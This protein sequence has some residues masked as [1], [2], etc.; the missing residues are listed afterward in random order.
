MPPFEPLD[1]RSFLVASVA[2]SSSLLVDCRCTPT[3]MTVEPLAGFELVRAVRDL[4][5]AS[6]DHLSARAADVIATKDP[7]TAVRF[8]RD[9]IAVLPPSTS[10]ETSIDGVRFGPNAVLRAG[11]GTLRERA[12]LLVA[13]LNAMG[14]TAK[15][16]SAPRPASLTAAELYRTRP[17]LYGVDGAKLTQAARQVEAQTLS[18]L[19]NPSQDP[20]VAAVLAKVQA[21]LPTSMMQA[22][23][24]FDGVDA[25]LPLV[26]YSFGGL[27]RWAYAVGTLDEVSTAP[28]SVSGP[29]SATDFPTVSIKLLG[30]PGDVRGAPTPTQLVELVAASWRTDEVAGRRV[31]IAFPPPDPANVIGA[32]PERLL[33]RLPTISLQSSPSD[34]PAL[35][36]PR[37]SEPKPMFT[38]KAITL[39]GAAFSAPASE[40]G[41]VIGP[42]GAFANLD[43]TS[44]A[45][46]VANVATIEA[47]AHAGAFP[48]IDLSVSV[49][50]AGGNPVLGLTAEDFALTDEGA[51]Q[52]LNVLSNAAPPPLKVLLAYDCSGS[53]TFPTAQARAAFENTLATAFV[54][55]AAQRPFSLGTALVGSAPAGYVAPDRTTI[56]AT[57]AA[58]ASTSDIW[59]TLGRVALEGGASVV[60]IASD[61]DASDDPSTIPAL[62][63]RLAASGIAVAAVPLGTVS[64]P[65]LDA[66]L[67]LSR[68]VKLDPSAPTFGQQLTDFIGAA[69][70]RA[71]LSAYRLR[72]RLAGPSPVEK[73]QRTATVSVRTVSGNAAYQVPA[74]AERGSAGWGAL[75]LELT[76]GGVTVTRWLSG[77]Q[78]NRFG[79][80]DAPPEARHFDETLGLIN[81]LTTI[82]FEPDAPTM[83]ALIDELLSSAAATEAISKV[84]GKSNREALEALKQLSVSSSNLAAVLT[85]IRGTETE[86]RTTTKNLRVVVMSELARADSVERRIDVVPALNTSIAATRDPS[87]AFR[88]NLVK[89]LGLSLREAAASRDS[90]AT[91]LAGA[92]LQ[93]LPAFAAPQTL[94]GFAPA[95]LARWTRVFDEYVSWHRLVPTTPSTEAMWVIDPATGTTFSVL[96]DGTGGGAW[97]CVGAGA[98]A[99]LSLALSF[100]SFYASVKSIACTPANVATVPGQ[101]SCVGATQASVAAGVVALFAGAFLDTASYLDLQLFI[102]GIIVSYGPALPGVLLGLA[103]FLKSTLDFAKATHDC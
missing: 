1:R 36:R 65:T 72:Y 4:V 9:S 18:Q 45:A 96:L 83:G 5:R 77:P 57:L 70:R 20:D 31:L 7:T 2:A 46:A 27:T 61:F 21:V 64:Q 28:A 14:A 11:A 66:V 6:P 32:P 30:L 56:T 87:E 48:E 69:T 92:S 81:G 39:G 102:I 8:V 91:T 29:L 12:D 86:P 89:G 41:P 88:A 17:P 25:H 16:V 79:G 75:F 33:L 62:Q 43:S 98:A 54:D 53:V 58:C 15:V 23:T 40:G 3:P 42:F 94:N 103:G 24:P 59:S 44:H 95:D 55:S 60:V 74:I 34:D 68:G 10:T 71:A 51:A 100:L 63:R 73:S 50:D 93:L 22:A 99:G 101:W 76:V 84:V 49:L 47:T 85:P 37:P 90:S 19:A 82:A 78:R 67:T 13:M 38:G 35:W 97:H 80:F 52:Q 26:E